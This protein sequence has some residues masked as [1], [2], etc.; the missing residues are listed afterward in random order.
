MRTPESCLFRQPAVPANPSGDAF[1]GLVQELT[2]AVDPAVSQVDRFTCEHC[3]AGPEPSRNRLNDYFASHLYR[4]ALALGTRGGVDGCDADKVTSLI[5]FAGNQLPVV[6]IENPDPLAYV[7]SYSRNCFY[8]GKPI[9]GLDSQSF[10]GDSQNRSYRC[11][12]E[13]IDETTLRE[14]E[15]C[16]YYDQ[17]GRAHV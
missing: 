3:C 16:R 11:R 8:L 7:P 6:N 5:E 10:A 12:H 15:S 4:L 9:D 1:C 14:C 17:I 13:L 2:G